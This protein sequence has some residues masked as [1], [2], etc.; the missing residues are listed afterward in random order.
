M[1]PIVRGLPVIILLAVAGLV[2]T[3]HAQPFGIELHNTMMP[4]AGGM[5]GVSIAQPL[6]P[7]AA[8]NGNPA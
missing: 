7:L 6:E 2:G 3:A 8:I 5:G 4:I 1:H